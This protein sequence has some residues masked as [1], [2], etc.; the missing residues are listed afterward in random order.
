VLGGAVAAGPGVTRLSG[1]V[2]A[3]DYQG[4]TA[5][6]FI[7]VAGTRLQAIGMIDGAPLVEGAVAEIAIRAA[8]CVLLED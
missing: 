1:R 2:A 4:T 5:R 7:D 3:V 8:D 6:Y